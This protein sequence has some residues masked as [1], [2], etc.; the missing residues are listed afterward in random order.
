MAKS[1]LIVCDR[2][3]YGSLMM[4]ESLDVATAAAAFDLPVHLL[5]RGDGVYGALDAQ[6][7]DGLQSKSTARQLGALMV[8]GVNGL[9]V[10]AEA[11]RDR[12]LDAD[13]LI[14]EAQ[15]VDRPEIDR[16]YAAAD[17]TVQL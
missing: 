17:C 3:P 7:A 11:L 13:Q 1:Y 15:V 6:N 12:N 2:S 14:A 9:F 16:L 5:L 8:Y 4:K 10:D